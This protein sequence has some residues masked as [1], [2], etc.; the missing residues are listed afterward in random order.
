MSGL[1]I[2]AFIVGLS[3]L[4]SVVEKPLTIWKSLAEAKA[5]G[6]DMTGIVAQLSMEYY[7]FFAWCRVSGALQ[8]NTGDANPNLPSDA[9]LSFNNNASLSLEAPIESAIA[10]IIDILT[11]VTEI[12]NKYRDSD[13]SSVNPTTRKPNTSVAHA[14]S[15]VLPLVGA[16]HNSGLVSKLVQQRQAANVLQEKTSFRLRFTFGS[17]PWGE[18]DK[19]A[20]NEKVQKLCYWNDRLERIIPG[21]IRSTLSSQALPAHM[22]A[23]ENQKILDTL[24]EASQND[25]V[26]V[27]TH[28]KLWQERLKF[29]KGVSINASDWEKYRRTNSSIDEI[30]GFGKSTCSVT[31]KLFKDGQKPPYICVVEW[32]SYGT[33]DWTNDDVQIATSRIAGLVHMSSQPEIPQSLRILKGLCFV[34]TSDAVGLVCKIPDAA[35]HSKQPVS[36]SSLMRK[37][38]QVATG[39]KRPSLERRLQLAQDLASAI[40]SFGLIRWFHKDFNS[41]NVVFFRDKA[42]PAAILFDSPYIAGFSIAR[43]DTA[44]QKSLDVNREAQAIYMHPD[45]RRREPNDRPRYHRKYEMYSLGLVLCEIAMWATIDRMASSMLEPEAFKSKITKICEEDMGFFVP[46]RYC[47]LVVRCLKCADDADEAASSLDTLYWS[48]VLELAK[49]RY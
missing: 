23:D 42:E 28:G 33:L 19:V 34:E 9:E 47:D 1:E 40:Y 44:A 3:G 32:Y 31:L 25:K 30:E 5:F 21:T 35:N 48:V 8:E 46:R 13:T 10:R 49:C 38:T 17:K 12:S 20:L 15:T 36:L 41:Q 39:F 7:R 22:L 6:A 11:E 24:I 45:L 37:E 2:P 29:E 27:R 18:S 26:S 43:P 14:L 16:K 4:I